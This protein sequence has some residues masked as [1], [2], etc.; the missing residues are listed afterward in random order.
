MQIPGLKRN[1]SCGDNR[2]EVDQGGKVVLAES[3]FT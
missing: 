1:N 2:A 3:W